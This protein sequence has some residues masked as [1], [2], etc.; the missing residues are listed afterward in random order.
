LFKTGVPE[1]LHG[2]VRKDRHR[3]WDTNGL[4][5]SMLYI[6]QS[7]CGPQRATISFPFSA[8]AGICR[9]QKGNKMK[10]ALRL[11]TSGKIMAS[12]NE[13]L[14][15]EIDSLKLIIISDRPRVGWYA[16]DSELLRSI[17]SI[18]L[19]MELLADK[20]FSKSYKKFNFITSDNSCNS[21]DKLYELAYEWLADRRT[22]VDLVS[23]MLNE[24][25]VFWDQFRSCANEQTR[26]WRV[27]TGHFG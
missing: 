19:K 17:D 16:F 12:H 8:L 2:K 3:Y 11:L 10:I 18:V 4:K 15:S 5:S 27:I 14:S 20:Y 23:A 25:Q 6:A 7:Y 26:K 9:H 22:M 13:S 21:R 1:Y 24:I